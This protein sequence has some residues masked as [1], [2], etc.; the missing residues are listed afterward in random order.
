MSTRDALRRIQHYVT[1]RRAK[2]LGALGDGVHSIHHGTEF[3]AD[4]LFSDLC[5]VADAGAALAADEKGESE[6][7]AARTE[8]LATFHTIANTSGMG[9]AAAR[10]LARAILAKHAPKE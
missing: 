10:E 8:M 3:A 1:M 5:A 4:L 6:L 7:V 2:P 9:G